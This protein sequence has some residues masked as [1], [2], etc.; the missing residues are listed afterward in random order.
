MLVIFFTMYGFL[1]ST[2][3]FLDPLLPYSAKSSAGSTL[4]LPNYFCAVVLPTDDL[5]ECNHMYVW[6]S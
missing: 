1:D 2:D 3:F 4:V 5:V 6:H